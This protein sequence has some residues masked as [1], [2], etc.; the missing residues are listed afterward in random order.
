MSSNFADE[1][2]PTTILP[3]RFRAARVGN[4]M[5]LTLGPILASI[6]GTGSYNISAVRHENG[7][8]NLLFIPLPSDTIITETEEEEPDREPVP[9]ES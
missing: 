6:L 4:S 2:D 7:R 3:R 5:M 8:V 1:V 9:S